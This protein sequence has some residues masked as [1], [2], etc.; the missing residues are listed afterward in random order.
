MLDL[1]PIL[2]DSVDTKAF[3]KRV[4]EPEIQK[5]THYLEMPPRDTCWPIATYRLRINHLAHASHSWRT[6][7]RTLIDFQKLQPT[8]S[9]TR[10]KFVD[11]TMREHGDPSFIFKWYAEK[12]S[13]EKFRLIRLKN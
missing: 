8:S 2:Y 7:L 3:R 13:P 11:F 12:R 4:V 6:H 9:I 5:S 1:G 10:M